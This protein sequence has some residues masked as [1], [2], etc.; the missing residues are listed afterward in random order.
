MNE[1]EGVKEDGN[2]KQRR[3]K[4]MRRLPSRQP[5]GSHGGRAPQA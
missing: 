3:A 2:V 5:S 4:E 1:D